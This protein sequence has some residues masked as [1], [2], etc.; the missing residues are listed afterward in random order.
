[1]IGYRC[2]DRSVER[3]GAQCVYNA[4]CR[5]NGSRW[6]REAIDLPSTLPI[7]LPFRWLVPH[8]NQACPKTGGKGDSPGRRH[9]HQ[10]SHL[11]QGLGLVATAAITA[12]SIVGFSVKFVVRRPFEDVRLW[13]FSVGLVRSEGGWVGGKSFSFY[14][15]PWSNPPSIIG[16]RELDAAPYRGLAEMAIAI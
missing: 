3:S 15:S 2:L 4:M 9:T 12:F 14:P 7:G 1:M 10:P 8:T 11:C 5:F 16:E 6:A 13:S